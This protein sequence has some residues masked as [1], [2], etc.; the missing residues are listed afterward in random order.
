MM[1]KKK[2]YTYIVRCSDNTLYTGWTNDLNH[3]VKCHNE[4][5]GAK[6]TKNRTP[7][8]LVYY[9]EFET[10][11]EAMQREAEIKKLT[12]A[13]KEQLVEQFKQI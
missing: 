3:R 13:K 7:V 12:K 1:E 5:K 4:K 10:K 6:Y 11:S 2:N 9:E 8:S